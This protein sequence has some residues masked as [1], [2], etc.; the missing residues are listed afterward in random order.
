M[1]RKISDPVDMGALQE[2]FLADARKV[3]CGE[4]P[5]LQISERLFHFLFGTVLSSDGAHRETCVHA[6]FATLETV[7][8]A[9]FVKEDL[10][11][12]RQVFLIRPEDEGR[13]LRSQGVE[14]SDLVPS[15]VT[16]Q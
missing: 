10:E 6:V 4:K 3:A 9:V 8:V 13:F 15:G 11:G 12:D 14:E 5:G 7:G 1:T 2:S 16:L